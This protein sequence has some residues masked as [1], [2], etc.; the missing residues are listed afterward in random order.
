M[1]TSYG[2]INEYLAIEEELK[3]LNARRKVL[4]NKKKKLQIVIEKMIEEDPA[5]KWDL[6]RGGLMVKEKPMRGRLKKREKLEQY[7]EILND[8]HVNIPQKTLEDTVKKIVNN[9]SPV[10]KTTY[11]FVKKK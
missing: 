4:L 8:T 6:E 11:D 5:V 9:K 3:Q 7:T 2:D 1:S 10:V